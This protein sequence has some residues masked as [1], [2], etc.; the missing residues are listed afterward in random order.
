MVH[1]RLVQEV[2]FHPRTI[3]QVTKLSFKSVSAEK[4]ESVNASLGTSL[5]EKLKKKKMLTLS[6][7]EWREE[8]LSSNQYDKNQKKNKS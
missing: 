2:Q 7:I 8:S 5:Y 6:F 4:L 1:L 3:L